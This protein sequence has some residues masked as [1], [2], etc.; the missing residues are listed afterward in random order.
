MVPV[1]IS[2]KYALV[3]ASL[4]A[5][6]PIVDQIVALIENT[7]VQ[8]GTAD[9]VSLVSA[10]V[11]AGVTILSRGWQEIARIWNKPDGGV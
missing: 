4:A 1:G 7:D 8:W 2:T 6:K 5:L 10:A 9:K 3:F 11:V